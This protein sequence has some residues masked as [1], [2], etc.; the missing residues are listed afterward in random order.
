MSVLGADIVKNNEMKAVHDDDL[1]NLLKSLNMYDLV[2]G[3]KK[4]CLFCGGT[5][6]FDNIDSIVPHEGMVEFTCNSQE[7]HTKLI[8]W[9]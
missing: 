1:G 8:G 5:I 6:T 9:K 4:K 7:C 2:E 3:G